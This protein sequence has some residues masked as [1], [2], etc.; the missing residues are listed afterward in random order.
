MRGWA[1]LWQPP[2]KESTTSARDYFERA[3]K[4]DPQNAEAMVGLAYAR[5]RASVYGWSTAAEDKP[6][7]A[8]G[9]ADESDRD[10][11]RLCL[12]L[13]REEHRVVAAQSSFRKR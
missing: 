9:V 7:R 13:L 8:V 10:Q 6:R 1:A 3:I 5:L 11:S 4:L 2:T 12:R